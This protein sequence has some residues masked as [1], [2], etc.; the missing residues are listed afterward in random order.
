VAA[1]LLTFLDLG[2]KS[3]ALET[4]SAESFASADEVCVADEDGYIRNQRRRRAPVVLIDG[5]LEF[6]YAEN[7]GAAFGFLRDFEWRRYIFF[8][9]ALFALLLLPFMLM[10]G[11]GGK[12]FAWSV[13]FIMAGAL[14][15]LH[16]RVVHGFVVDFI[17]FYFRD[18]FLFIDPGWEYPTFNVADIHITVGVV[19]ILLDGFA[20]TRRERARLEAEEAAAAAQSAEQAPVADADSAAPSDAPASV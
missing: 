18:G 16:D 2:S 5:I 9:A 11:Q 15:N 14:G 7:C 12:L 10:R 19:L 8:P 13:P 4:L 6:S 3:W 20:E 17:R 1:A